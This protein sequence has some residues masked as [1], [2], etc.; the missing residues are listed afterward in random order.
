MSIWGDCPT[1][2]IQ[3]LYMEFS[4]F[5]IVN[6]ATK[7]IGP[8]NF[9]IISIIFGSLLGNANAEKCGHGTIIKINQENTHKD[10]ILWLHN[11]ISNLG[12]CK[13]S[14]PI[15]TTRL[16]LHGKLKNI[17][18]L[19]TYT[20]SSLNWIYDSFYI[21]NKKVLPDF[22]LVFQYLSP[23]ALAIWIM[24]NGSISSTGMKITTNNFTLKEVS[25]LVTILN[26]KY[27]LAT[28][29]NLSSVPNKYIIYIPKKNVNYLY[30][31]VSLYIHPS[32][33]YKFHI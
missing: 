5:G 19:K 13:L 29:I 18:R 12:Y 23:L 33:K 32:M 3:D 21:N 9:N 22:Y 1:Y 15:I 20:F 24:D 11:L 6:R 25:I 30:D 4:I 31:I 14:I 27:N 16:S 17:L 26:I 8:H 10:Y 2:I 7:R 28:S